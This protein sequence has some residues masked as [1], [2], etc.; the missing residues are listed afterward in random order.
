MD[1]MEHTET[2][3][4][5]LTKLDFIQAEIKK[6]NER[7]DRN[8]VTREKFESLE[9]KVK[10]NTRIREWATTL[11]VGSVIVALLALIITK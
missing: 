10:I 2:S 11:I 6:I 7:L 8:Y 1:T 4:V 3:E 9:G 5:I